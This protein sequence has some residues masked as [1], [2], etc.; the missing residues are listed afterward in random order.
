MQ[1][2]G[3]D[4]YLSEKRKAALPHVKWVDRPT[5]F[6][7]ADYITVHTPLSDETRYIVGTETLALM[8][9][10]AWVINTSRGGMVDVQ[11]LAEALREKKIGGA[12]IDVY[13]VE[14]PPP[15]F[16]L[17]GFDNVILTPHLGWASEESGQDIRESIMEDILAFADGRPARWVVNREVLEGSA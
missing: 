4:P 11:A 13:E 12:A 9:P 17:Y 6:R 16:P 7:E 5:L 10:T 14:P 15:S 1:I 8:K 2:L 3:C